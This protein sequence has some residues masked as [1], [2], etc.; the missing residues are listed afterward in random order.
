MS[1]P[2]PGTRGLSL[3]E[4]LRWLAIAVVCG[5]LAWSLIG[6]SGGPEV[7]A[8]APP[9]EVDTLS[10][11]PF[12][13]A[14]QKGRVVVL[15]FWATWCPPCIKSLPALERLHARYAGSPD[16]LI[17]SVNTDAMPDRAQAL[18]KWMD[19]RKFTF[20]VLLETRSKVLSNAYRVQSIPTMVVIGRSGVVHDVHVGLPANDID[21]IEAHVEKR[22]A[23]ALAEGG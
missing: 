1:G 19:R 17:A 14:D 13:L 4:T 8:P 3:F 11:T 6:T 5:A 23:E 9:I 16:V 2:R 20:P 12:S 22:I 18:Q 10:G 21:G 15:D 7:G